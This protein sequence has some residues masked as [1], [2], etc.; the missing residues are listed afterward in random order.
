MNFIFRCMRDV[1]HIYTCRST[2]RTT[3]TKMGHPVISRGE[4]DTWR[5]VTF[6]DIRNVIRRQGIVEKLQLNVDHLGTDR[7]LIVSI[8]EKLSGACT[9]RRVDTTEVLTN[10]SVGWN[11]VYYL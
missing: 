6:V 3:F 5:K 10:F 1:K 11:E 7:K 9:F 4:V 8:Y 2:E